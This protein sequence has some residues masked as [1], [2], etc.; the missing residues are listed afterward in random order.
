MQLQASYLKT[1][2]SLNIGLKIPARRMSASRWKASCHRSNVPRDHPHGEA[3]AWQNEIAEA[4]AIAHPSH[5]ASLE[6]R[7]AASCPLS[8]R[9]ARPPA[10]PVHYLPALRRLR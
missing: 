7:E 5:R 3:K 2:A 6:E 9:Y 8:R 1:T 10:P 4:R